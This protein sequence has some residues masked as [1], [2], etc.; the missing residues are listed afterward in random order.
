MTT[1]SIRSQ[2]H[3]LPNHE[4][5]EKDLIRA[6]MKCSN[7]RSQTLSP[8]TIA[9]PI[10]IPIPRTH[11]GTVIPIPSRAAPPVRNANLDALPIHARPPR[12]AGAGRAISA[13]R[14]ARRRT[15]HVAERLE[16]GLDSH[17]IRDQAL[18]L[19]DHPAAPARPAAVV[20]RRVK[21][22]RDHLDGLC[23]GRR[24]GRR[25]LG[26]GWRRRRRRFEG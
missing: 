8:P 18:P 1:Y 25:G 20:P 16:L 19:D 6:Q 14:R 15:L 12:R 11:S 22:D 21:V 13:S 24:R 7:N 10:R 2:S 4:S 3:L 17:G 26:F 5:T 9:F 23:L